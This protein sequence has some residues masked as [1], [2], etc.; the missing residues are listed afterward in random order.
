MAADIFVS[1]APQDVRVAMTLCAALESRG[2]TCWMSARDIEPGE[3]LPS[4]IEQALRR[5]RIMLLVFTAHANTS[6]EMAEE[7]ALANRHRLIVIPLRVEDAT[8]NDALAYEFATRP[9]ID[10]VA[11]WDLAID[12][13]S[14]RV[15]Q[16]VPDRG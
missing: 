6:A 4:A 10:A 8:P 5:A 13:L 2:L 16:A 9:W 11:D 12:Q 14:R 15:G 7:L 1:F 3:N